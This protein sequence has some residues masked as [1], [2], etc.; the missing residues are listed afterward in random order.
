[1][2]LP[3]RWIKLGD[4]NM[5]LYDRFSKRMQSI[6]EMWPIEE[7]LEDVAVSNLC[8]ST[9]VFWEL[10]NWW[11]PWPFPPFWYQKRDDKGH[12][13]LCTEMPWY[14]Y[15]ISSVFR[16]STVYFMV[17]HGISISFPNSLASFCHIFFLL[18]PGSAASFVRS[19]PSLWCSCL[20]GRG[21]M[22]W[23][24]MK[25]VMSGDPRW[26]Q[27]IPGWSPKQ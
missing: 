4:D 17:F 6:V 15:G 3:L 16:G 18:R 14:S 9:G 1:M 2:L 20:V 8:R 21:P 5:L 13:R 27:V 19:C 11:S 26:C 23:D 12:I 24:W 22:V 10:G 25:Q 7:M